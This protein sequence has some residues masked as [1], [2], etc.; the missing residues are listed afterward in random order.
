[1]ILNTAI[2]LMKSSREDTGRNSRE[3]EALIH[4]NYIMTYAISRFIMRKSIQQDQWSSSHYKLQMISNLDDGVC[5]FL[6]E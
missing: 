3:Q 4:F 6:N 5:L 2:K 1:M